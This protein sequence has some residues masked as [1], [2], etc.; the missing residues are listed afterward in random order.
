M[1][2]A[3]DGIRVVD[4]GRVLAE[5][6]SAALLADLGAE[7]IRVEG[8]AGA[9]D[10]RPED[11]ETFMQKYPNQVAPTGDGWSFINFN[12][13]KKAISLNFEGRG[14]AN[15]KAREILKELVRHCDV[16]MENFSPRTAEAM[17]ITYDNLRAIKPDIIFAH[18]SAFGSSGPYSHRPGYDPVAKAMAGIMMISGPPG[19]PVR[20]AISYVDYGTALLTTVGV[21]TALYHRQRTGQGQMIETALLRTALMYSSSFITQWETAGIRHER[22][23]NQPFGVGP[24]NAFQAK[25]GRWVYI[26]M[27]GNQIW[28]RF[29]RFI[30]REDLATDPRLQNDWDRW[31]H[32]DITYPVVTEWV[33][34]QTAEEIVAAA[35]KIP[36]PC[37]FCY[38][39]TEVA[40][41]PHIKETGMLTEVP[42]PDGT[43]VL[44]SSSP[45][46]M[47]ATPPKIERSFPAVGEHNEE[48]YCGLLGYSRKDLVRFK[49]EG[50][51]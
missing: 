14:E 10:R 28:R 21:L 13:N 31:L 50:I 16:V 6:Y 33:A 22:V 9:W 43:K 46:L 26:G 38:E 25:D 20:D 41:D 47:S 17:G 49:K 51:I 24:S 42:C 12:R 29:C 3:L 19:P 36:I 15:I 11:W 8:S 2:G 27:M 45:L 39:I 37:G 48:I 4:L 30:G 40:H 23:G 32:R 18:V 1:P 35:E 7:V 44:V 5:P 34:S